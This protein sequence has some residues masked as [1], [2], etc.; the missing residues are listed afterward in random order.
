[1]SDQSTSRPVS[2]LRGDPD[3]SLL[4]TP[5]LRSAFDEAIRDPELSAALGYGDEQGLKELRHLLVERLNT[6][7]SLGIDASQIM[8]VPGS[9]GAIDMIARLYV[10]PGSVVIV[11]SPTYVDAI[12]VFR[13]HRLELVGVPI[14]QEGPVTSLLERRLEEL[15]AS[16]RSVSLLYLIPTFHNPTGVTISAERRTE[17][18]RLAREFDFVIV[19]DD[20]YREISFGGKQPATF[21]R[22]SEGHGVFSIGSFSKTLA[23]GLRLGWLIAAPDVINRCVNCGTTQMGSGASPLSAHL[24][25]RYMAD[26]HYDA[27]LA[28]LRRVY[29][30]RRDLTLASL[31]RHMPAGTTWTSPEGG[32]FVWMT[33]SAGAAAEVCRLASA[34]GVAIGAGSAFFLDPGDGAR[35]LRLAYSHAPLDRIDSAIA[36]LAAIV[37]ELC[38]TSEFA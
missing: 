22:V 4:A 10:R 25:H 21:Y 27:H 28:E 5:G 1:M 19:E 9:T 3:L 32:F 20:P 36:D 18:V 12:H 13:D 33:L 37:R 2:F 14:D 7:E 26:G 15:R 23:P 24:V 30:Q 8:L 31:A 35:S 38:L 6:H 29:G 11:E 34:R 17:I 16:G